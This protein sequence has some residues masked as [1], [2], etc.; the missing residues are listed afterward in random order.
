MRRRW[1]VVILTIPVL[2]GGLVIYLAVAIRPVPDVTLTTMSRLAPGMTEAEVA[3]RLGEPT[4]DL[5]AAPPVAAP[6]PG[7]NGR[8]L[9][10]AGDA[11]TAWVEY[12]QHGHLVRWTPGAVRRV[13]AYERVRLRLDLW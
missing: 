9:E 4:A 2:L 10:Y 12:D 6:A 1:K 3:A 5:T 13:S 11:A 8:L 7:V